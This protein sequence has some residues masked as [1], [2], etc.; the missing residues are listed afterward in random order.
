ALVGTA[1]S[2]HHGHAAQVGDAVA[3]SAAHVVVDRDLLPVGPRDGVDIPQPLATFRTVNARVAPVGHPVYCREVAACPQT[4]DQIHQGFL[5]LPQ[6]ANVH[7]GACLENVVGTGCSVLAA[8]HDLRLGEA[9]AYFGDQT[10]IVGP[11]G[12]KHARQADNVDARVDSRDD[13]IH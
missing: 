1:T 2:G 11:R 12:R 6:D 4:A 5:A 9:L 7:G 13:L 8:H 10:M 3:K